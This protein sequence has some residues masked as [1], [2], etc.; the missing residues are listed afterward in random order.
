MF[1]SLLSKFAIVMFLIGSLVMINTASAETYSA[2]L[3]GYTAMGGSVAFNS[4]PAGPNVKDKFAAGPIDLP[5][6]PGTNYWAYGWAK[7]DVGTETVDSA[8]LTLDLIGAGGM[9]VSPAAP[10]RLAILDIYNPG[11]ADI[12]Q[13]VADPT[14][15]S[16]LRDSL[17]NG[18]NGTSRIVDDFT[19]DANGTYTFDITSMYNGWVD[20][21]IVNNGLVFASN[22][23]M[24]DGTPN[25]AS[26]GNTAG[27]APFIET[28]V[29]AVPV[30]GAFLLFGCGLVGLIGFIRRDR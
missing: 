22:T 6:G 20:G 7:F 12:T 15:R 10:D 13:I 24:I 11:S 4:T 17:M 30:P 23:G 1:K 21:S 18:T 28:F 16:D 8:L 29:T 14:V 5:L 9:Q 27:N 19:M 25:F 3:T 2:N 26:F